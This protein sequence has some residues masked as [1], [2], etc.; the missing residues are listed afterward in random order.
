MPR[1]P[2]SYN[3]KESNR[4]MA[5]RLLAEGKGRAELVSL[6]RENGSTSRSA[7]QYYAY[8]KRQLTKETN[9][10]LANELQETCNC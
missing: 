9:D 5:V 7:E 3:I 2:G 6:L 1:P 10:D 8:A 4:Q